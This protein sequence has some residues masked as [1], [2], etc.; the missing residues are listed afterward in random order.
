MLDTNIRDFE[1]KSPSSATETLNTNPSQW[2]KSENMY[3]VFAC[4]YQQNI[5][6]ACVV[7]ENVGKE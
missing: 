3:N 1:A 7:I 6:N 5:F 2:I 4:L